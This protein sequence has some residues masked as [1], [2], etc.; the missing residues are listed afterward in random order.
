MHGSTNAVV[1]SGI[2]SMSLSW[3]CWKPRML[4]PSKP[5]PSM[6]MSSS[7]SLTGIEKCCRPARQVDEPEVDHEDAALAGERHHVGDGGRGRGDAA[8]NPLQDGHPISN[9][10]DAALVHDARDRGR[11]A[12]CRQAS[13]G[14]GCGSVPARASSLG[15]VHNCRVPQLR[16]VPRR[17]I[18]VAT[19]SANRRSG[20]DRSQPPSASNRPTRYATVLRWTPSRAAA[21][22]GCPLEHRLERPQPLLLNCLPPDENGRQQL[23]RLAQPVGQ[24]PD[25]REQQVCRQPRRAAHDRRVVERLDRLE[26]RPR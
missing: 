9:L 19:P 14:L 18:R 7:S 22:R 2:S 16:Q 3:I 6:N 24:V 23:P 26:R 11:L 5:M 10:H 20:S 4:E 17:R 25:V 13:I 12:D 15:I 21:S 8:R 1:G